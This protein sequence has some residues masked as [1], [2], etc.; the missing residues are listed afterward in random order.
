MLD[1]AF[2]PHQNLHLTQKLKLKTYFW[3]KFEY[4][5]LNQIRYMQK[6]ALFFN[7]PQILWNAMYGWSM[8]IKKFV[9]ILYSAFFALSHFILTNIFNLTH[10]YVFFVNILQ[11]VNFSD[12]KPSPTCDESSVWWKSINSLNFLLFRI[13]F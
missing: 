1:S 7:S 8:K 4:I 10:F 12:S 6:T 5:T 11:K 3:N 9:I 2:D 13:S